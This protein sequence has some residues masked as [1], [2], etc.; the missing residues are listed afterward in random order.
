MPNSS[1]CNDES[2]SNNGD[3]LIPNNDESN[4]L[5]NDENVSLTFDTPLNI[6]SLFQLIQY[7]IHNG[8]KK[9]SLHIMNLSAV[10]E[11]FFIKQMYN[12]SRYVQS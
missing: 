8:R 7:N 9:T 5:N 10:Y 4:L 1:D 2:N 3:P 11:K 6:K 12:Y